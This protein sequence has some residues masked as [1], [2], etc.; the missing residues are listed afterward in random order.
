MSR[1]KISVILLLAVAHILAGLFGTIESAFCQQKAY[2]DHEVQ[3]LVGFAP[4]GGT[5]VVARVL[6]EGMKNLLK[7][8]IIVMNKPGGGGIL[9]LQQLVHSTPDGY[10]LMFSSATPV[11]GRYTEKSA[12]T[13]NDI[14]VIAM[15]NLDPSVVF[16]KP[17]SQ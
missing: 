5:D 7:Q 12:P 14:E 11:T 15:A 4:G 16:V 8:P 13:L 9:A 2:P 17:D 10:T 3:I 6:A 1:K